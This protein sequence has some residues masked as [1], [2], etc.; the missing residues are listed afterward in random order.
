VKVLG[1]VLGDQPNPGHG[2]FREREREREEGAVYV[3]MEDAAHELLGG[4]G[5]QP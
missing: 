4:K 2:W 1:L 3:M 5:E